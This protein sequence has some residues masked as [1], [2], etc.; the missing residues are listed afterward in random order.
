ME[1]LATVNYEFIDDNFSTHRGIV[2]P[3]G[4][5]STKTI[6]TLQWLILYARR[7]DDKHIV[8][9]RDTLKNL[10]RTVLKDFISLCY[11]YGDYAPHD[12]NMTLNKSELIATV[13]N[14]TFEFIGLIDDPMRVH[15]LKSDIFYINEAIGTYKSTFT[16]LNYRCKEGWI[17]DCNPSEPMHWVYELEQREDVAFFRSTY[18]DNPFLNDAQR[19]EIESK[20]PTKENIERGTADERE[21]SIYG[22]GEVYRGK[23]IIYPKW[24]TY[25]GEISEYDHLFYGLDWGVNHPLACV[26]VK[27]NGNNLYVREIVYK[28]GITD[29]GEQLVP[30]LMEEPSIRDASTYVVCDSSEQK[31]IVTLATHNIPAFAVK[32]P[33]GSV[34]D[35]IRKVS[36]FNIFVHE[37]S[38]NIQKELNSYKWKI[39]TKTDTVLDVPVKENDDAMDAIRYVVYTFL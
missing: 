24:S 20:E 35:G 21:W 37:N 7:N 12:L 29:L 6:S 34:L 39:D 2:L 13:G 16:Q 19:F 32:K 25:T 17:L 1:V 18:L 33:A 28:S 15:G 9:A 31:S 23:E 26:E 11:G 5:R 22:K 14:S 10:K 38:Q 36:K 3:G 30:I 4:T 8:I 27:V